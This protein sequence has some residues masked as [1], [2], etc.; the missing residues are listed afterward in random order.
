MPELWRKKEIGQDCPP[1]NHSQPLLF[2]LQDM[3]MTHH[4]NK[5]EPQKADIVLAGAGLAGLTLAVQLAN[6]PYF[7]QQQV[8]IVE[9]DTKTSNDRTWCFWARDSE[10]IPPVVYK[11]WDFADF[12]TDSGKKLPLA[13]NGYKYH[14]VRGQDF[15]AWAKTELSRHPNI[16]W[17]AAD[18]E[19]IDADQGIVRT[20]TADYQGVWVFNSA[21][22]PDFNQPGFTSLLQHFKGWII[23]TAD[24]QFN[25]ET[26]TLMDY[27]IEQA[28]ETR[29]VYVLPISARKALVEFTIFSKHLLPDADYD[30]ALQHYIQHQLGIAAFRVAEEEFGVIPMADTPVTQVDGKVIHIGT[31]GGFVKGSSG[32]AFKRTQ[33]KLAEFVAAWSKNN[34]PN[35]A[36]MRSDWRFRFYDSVMLRVLRENAVPGSAFFTSLFQK[37]PASLVFQFLDEDTTF[38]GDLR[39]MTAPPTWPFFMTALKQ[40]PQYPKL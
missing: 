1:L 31:A 3:T 38:A 6:H 21:I 9:R 35:P 29:F 26:V 36:L 33:R 25:P 30:K 22:R 28:G 40:I 2:H 13:M 12:Y 20:Y 7:E 8:L 11:S 5:R 39:L 37:L 15:Y 24:D 17:V 34:V 27:R 18:I 10:P 4:L 32:Y 16:R 19:S 23:E 14:M